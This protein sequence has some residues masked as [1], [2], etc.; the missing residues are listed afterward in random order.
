MNAK[1]KKA[2]G[3]NR[4]WITLL[5]LCCATG[6]VMVLRYVFPP[7]IVAT[8]SMIPTIPPGSFLLSVRRSLVPAEIEKNDVLVFKPVAG[9]SQ[10][11][12]VHRIVGISGEMISTQDRQGRVDISLE[13]IAR[14]REALVESF[15]IPNG[16]LYQS[17]DSA[18]SYY[19]LVP[20]EMV[21]GKMLF[22]FKLPW[23]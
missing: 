12:W 9:V 8:G 16:F 11:P 21:V 4:P 22:H 1:L 5:I 19:G 2:L 7:Y 14:H 6:L 20:E 10:Y 18:S 3:L 15:M 17:G 23:R 13:G